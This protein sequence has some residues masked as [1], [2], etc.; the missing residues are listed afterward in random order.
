M[1]LW[2]KKGMADGLLAE[3]GITRKELAKECDVGINELNRVL[4]GEIWA[5]AE[6][7]RLLFAAFGV[8]RLQHII[9]W[10]ATNVT[11]GGKG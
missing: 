8:D 2:L 11:D 10:T 4:D 9:D 1:G 3:H 5:G 7:S 6:L